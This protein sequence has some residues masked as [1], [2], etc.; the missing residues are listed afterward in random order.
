MENGINIQIGPERPEA[1]SWNWIGNHLLES[2]SEPF[3]ISIY[4][5]SETSIAPDVLIWIKIPPSIDMLERLPRTTKVIYAPIDFYGSSAEIDQDF[6]SL[7]RCDFIVLHT[8]RLEK[9]FRSYA[10]VETFDHPLKYTVPLRKEFVLSGPIL[11]VGVRDNLP[12]VIE[13]SNRNTLPE[14]L[15]ILTNPADP[16]RVPIASDYGFQRGNKVRM[17]VWSPEKQREWMQLARGAVDVKGADFRS[18]HKPPTKA[19]DFLASGLPLALNADTSPREYC[20]ELGFEVALSEDID[21][22]FSEEYWSEC[23]Q[24]GEKLQSL[25]SPEKV[26]QDWMNLLKKMIPDRG[27]MRLQRTICSRYREGHKE[28]D[29]IDDSSINTT[30]ESRVYPMK[31]TVPLNMSLTESSGDTYKIAL[32]SLLFNWPSTGGGTVHTFGLAHFLEKYGL[33]VQHIYAVYPS[34]GIGSVTE[35]LPYTAREL[36]FTPDQWNPETVRDRFRQAVDEFDPDVVIV[37]DSWNS[38][39]LLAESVIDH[40]YLLRL[41]AQECICP[42]NNVRLL[43]DETDN[44]E[45]TIRQCE[46]N[47]LADS[48]G[49][50]E[51]VTFRDHQSGA[52]HQ[53]DRSFAGFHEDDYADRL[54]QVFSKAAAVLVVNPEIEKLI[55]PYTSSVKVI[56]SGFDMNRFPDPDP[57]LSYRPDIEEDRASNDPLIFLF[58]GLPAE[59]MKGFHVLRNACDQLWKEEQNFRLW[60]TANEND[61]S[62]QRPYETYLGW[63]TQEELPKRIQEADVLVV[64]TI[65]QE[66][67]GRTA[68]EAMG[69]GRPVIAS[70][71]GGLPWTIKEGITGLLVEPGDSEDLARKMKRL[72]NDALLRRQLGLAGREEFENRFTWE[73]IIEQ[74]YV[75]LFESIR[76]SKDGTVQ[77]GN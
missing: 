53:H 20:A 32:L 28:S 38:K 36:S 7:C 18:R 25:L 34:W 21:R 54:Q 70:R 23:C 48:R 4:H 15:W 3:R 27:Q 51:C 55:A 69:C 22:W 12:P 52:L 71:I 17:D 44:H 14:E 35:P 41:A 65:A 6:L 77:V 49:C 46:Q 75:P 61:L 2:I 74:E 9:Y 72:M 24:F 58:A 63:Q 31:Y 37:T 1:G 40:P 56:P 33:D 11:W 10:P 16:T 5:P 68:V 47:Q 8:S 59:L 66:A 19:A 43:V 57:E 62:E 26:A 64:P 13:W 60:I 45:L 29:S 39:V 67:L 73:R 30:E 42:L 76:A 50:R